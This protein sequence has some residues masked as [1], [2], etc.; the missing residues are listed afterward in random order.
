MSILDRWRD[1]LIR[2]QQA[3]QQPCLIRISVNGR[4]ATTTTSNHVTINAGRV[5]VMPAKLDASSLTITFRGDEMP[6]SM[7]IDFKSL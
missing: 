5:I 2:K 1:N 7:T 3:P 6:S 4:P